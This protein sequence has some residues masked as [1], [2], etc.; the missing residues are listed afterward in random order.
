[1]NTKTLLKVILSAI[2]IFMIWEIIDTS[3]ESS[4]FE[5]WS[6]LSQIPWMEATLYDFYANV[7]C[8]S[9]WVLYKE[10]SITKKILW[11]LFFITMGSVATCIYL[12]KELF[13]L[14]ED[15]DFKTLLT[16]QNA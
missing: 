15:E 3:L 1:M 2:L 12:L 8:I 6:S 5:E 7:F 13:A 9:L 14:N 11:C 16:R 4:L 10:K